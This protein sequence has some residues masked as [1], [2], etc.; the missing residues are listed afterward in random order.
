[1]E[2]DIHVCIF[3][4]SI[5]FHR[6]GRSQIEIRFIFGPTSEI[7]KIWG[8]FWMKMSFGIL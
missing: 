4:S 5:G 8:E 6:K 7:N 1:M 3:I 2:Y